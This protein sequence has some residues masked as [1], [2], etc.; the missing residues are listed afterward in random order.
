MKRKN[1]VNADVDN[2]IVDADLLDQLS[3]IINDKTLEDAINKIPHPVFSSSGK[4]LVYDDIFFLLKMSPYSKII[5]PLYPYESFE[6]LDGRWIP[7]KNHF[8]DKIR[9]VVKVIFQHYNVSITDEYL[10]G[11]I[12]SY[13]GKFT[14]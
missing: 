6:T 7:G 2:M 10:D 1:S 13:E 12:K 5:R 4:K 14:E 9:P 11:A 8:S 3:S